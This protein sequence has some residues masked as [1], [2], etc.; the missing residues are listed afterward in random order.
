MFTYISVVMTEA[1]PQVQHKMYKHFK[2]PRVFYDIYLDC[3]IL[4]RSAELRVD[5]ELLTAANNRS[6]D[7]E[8]YKTTAQRRGALQSAARSMCPAVY[9]A[10]TYTT[11]MNTGRWS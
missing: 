8:D 3:G 7:T 9:I 2:L 4:G 10:V 5:V 11:N 6:H 1:V